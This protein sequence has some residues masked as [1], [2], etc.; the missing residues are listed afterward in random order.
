MD[1]NV[2]IAIANRLGTNVVKKDGYKCY[3]G[4]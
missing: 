2:M 1:T 4:F 3:N